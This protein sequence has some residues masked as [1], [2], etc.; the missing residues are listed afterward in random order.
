MSIPSF[1]NILSKK[2][3]TI[4]NQKAQFDCFVKKSLPQVIVIHEISF[5]ISI[6]ENEKQKNKGKLRFSR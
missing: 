1:H 3:L 6:I 4:H 2:S 5:P